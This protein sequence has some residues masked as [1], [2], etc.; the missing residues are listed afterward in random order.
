M[1]NLNRIF[2]ILILLCVVSIISANA[3]IT[4]ISQIKDVKPTEQHYQALQS[5]VE[6]YGV[7]EPFP[8]GTFRA[9][10]PLTRGEFVKLLN[11][12]LNQMMDLT[13]QEDV[14]ILPTD[15]FH[16]YNAN[17]TNITSASQIKDLR[18][19][20]E[21]YIPM[22]SLIERFGIDICDADKTFHAEKPVTEKEFYTWIK[23]I[24]GASV[25]GNPSAT[26]SLT[27]SVWVMIMN[28]AFDAVTERIEEKVA[29]NKVKETVPPK[30]AP[31]P[32]PTVSTNSTSTVTRKS[33][34][35]LI[36]ELP[37]LGKA[38]IVDK[39]SFYLPD[40]TCANLASAELELKAA[41]K[42]G[43]IW[44]NYKINEGDIGDI[45]YETNNTCTSGKIIIL[46]VGTA[47]IT[48]GEKGVK[49]IK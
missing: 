34:L 37:S 48:I 8:D 40:N 5:L 43:G 28:S 35:E 26:K 14:E 36:K 16:Y 24:F 12:G 45:V 44:G 42:G 20:N 9:N 31:K 33:K 46:R 41:L 27:R 39:G 6:K 13:T 30:V 19:T 21:F 23:G 25:E 11:S 2:S 1:K 18:P 15:L 4:S 22:E 10:A 7:F 29:K 32:A 3:Q 49:R 38:K 47:L 17:Q